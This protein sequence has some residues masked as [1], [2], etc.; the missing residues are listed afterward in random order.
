MTLC[1]CY[2]I[3]IEVLS[4]FQYEIPSEG[5]E[6]P[7]FDL[8]LKVLRFYYDSSSREDVYTKAYSLTQYY[9]GSAGF[10]LINLYV[11]T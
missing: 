11:N 3:I 1:L 6:P 4:C 10:V 8:G 7:Y 2:I 5:F 9:A